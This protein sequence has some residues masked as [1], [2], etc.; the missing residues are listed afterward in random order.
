MQLF[1]QLIGS[2]TLVYSI[3]EACTILFIDKDIPIHKSIYP[4]QKSIFFGIM[5]YAITVTPV[6]FIYKLPVVAK[7]IFSIMMILAMLS[8]I[9]LAG[10]SIIIWVCSKII[11]VLSILCREPYPQEIKDFNH[12]LVNLILD[13]SEAIITAYVTFGIIFSF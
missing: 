9:F 13:I 10:V 8:A 7:V 3:A 1:M 4:I 11:L 6:A 5:L 12:S 2:L